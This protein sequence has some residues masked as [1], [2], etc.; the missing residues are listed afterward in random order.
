MENI[1]IYR[2][3]DE[4]IFLKLF[5]DEEKTIPIDIDSLS[6]LEVRIS[7]GGHILG[8]WN[9]AGGGSFIAL[10]RIDKY[11]YYFWFETN[12]STKI[13]HAD[14]WIETIDS[15]SELTDNLNNSITAELNLFNIV[16]KPY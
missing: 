12:E 15:D 11:N 8:Q 10:T 5:Q 4:Q 16:Q 2:G 3:N 7:I 13:G 9:K 1:I 14:L 6:D